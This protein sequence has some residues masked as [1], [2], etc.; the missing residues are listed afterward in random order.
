[1]RLVSAALPK[2]LPVARALEPANVAVPRRSPIA[3]AMFGT[4]VD[5]VVRPIGV[6][7]IPRLSRLDPLAAAG[8]LD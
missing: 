1:M 5:L 4:G 6:T 8:A 7:E 2:E 3:P